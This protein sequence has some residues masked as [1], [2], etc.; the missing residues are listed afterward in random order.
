MAHEIAVGVMTF[1]ESLS[2]VHTQGVVMESGAGAGTS[3]AEAIA[4][5]PIRGSWWA[6]ARGKEIFKVTRAIRSCPD[7]LVCRLVGGKITYVHRRLWPALVRLAKRLPPSGLAQIC[8]I[9]TPSGQHVTKEIPYPN[10]VPE[11]LRNEAAGLSEPDAIAKLGP[12]ADWIFSRI[13]DA[14]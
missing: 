9:H 2:M 8:E 3:L 10:W 13:K 4:G 5:A 11:A 14:R 6:H 7:V 1:E 12:S